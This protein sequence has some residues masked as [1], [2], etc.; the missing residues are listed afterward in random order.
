[1]DLART[2]QLWFGYRRTFGKGKEHFLG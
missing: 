1:L 2:T